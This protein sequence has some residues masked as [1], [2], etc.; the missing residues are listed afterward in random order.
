MVVK[1]TAEIFVFTIGKVGT[2][3]Q[4]VCVVPVYEPLVWR[5]S[6]VV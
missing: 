5:H 4:Q 2:V 1:P 3:R 6:N